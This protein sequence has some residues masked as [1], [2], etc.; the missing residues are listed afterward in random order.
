MAKSR[1]TDYVPI[2]AYTYRGNL[3]SASRKRSDKAQRGEGESGGNS[4]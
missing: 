2:A 1:Q 4:M 3:T